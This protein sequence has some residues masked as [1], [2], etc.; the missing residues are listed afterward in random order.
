MKLL[1]TGATGYIGQQ[2]TSRAAA[3]GHEVIFA[4]R[5]PCSRPHAWIPYDLAEPAP[6]CPAGVQAIIHLA[7]NTSTNADIAADN[8]VQAA[9]ALIRCAGQVSAKFIFI[10]SQTAEATA[11]GAYGR[12]KWRIEQAVLAA[13]GVVIRPGQVYGGPERGLFGL[14]SGLIRQFPVIPILLPAPCVQPIHVDDLAASILAVVEREDIRGEV[15]NLGA[16]EPISFGRFLMAIATYRV[17]AVRLPVPLPVALLKLLRRCLGQSMSTRLGLERIFSL[18]QLPV[19]DSAP[20]LHKLG[21]ELR[22]LADGL[23]RSGRGQRRQYLQEGYVLLHYLLDNPPPRS[24]VRRYA[25]ALEHAGKT[26]PVIRSQLLMCSPILLT[27]LDHPGILNTP[28]GQDLVWRLQAALH[29]AEASPLGA[30]RFLGTQQQRGFVSS[31]MALGWTSVKALAW[32]IV[33]PLCRPLARQLFLGS[34]APRE[35]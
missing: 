11:A 34:E 2:L 23:H 18:I 26:R 14:L 1:I 30:K 28:G 24:L 27:L 8:E 20:A 35:A 10:S 21:I 9:Q 33:T 32:R 7:A 17:H 22:P 5:K 15:L 31:L 19:M 29:I 25:K 4:T 13:G 16:M 3:D 12:T 6:D